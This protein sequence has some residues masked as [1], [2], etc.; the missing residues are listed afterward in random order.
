MAKIRVLIADDHPIVRSGIRLLLEAEADLEVV[1]EAED[2]HGA[3]EL[4]ASLRPDVLT[5]DIEMPRLNGVAVARELSRRGDEVKILALSAYDDVQYIKGLLACGAAGFITKEEA[6][7]EIVVA[8]RGVAAGKRG[9]LSRRAGASLSE[10]TVQEA[11]PRKTLT[12]RE[13]EVLRNVAKGWSNDQVADELVISERTVRFHLSNIY[14][15]LDKANRAETIA[16]ALRNG[17]D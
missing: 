2:G 3:L 10:L 15:K 7:A 16:W 4:T 11:G 17:Y 9:W 8:V 13:K 12:E 14:E 6:V 1:G 5:L